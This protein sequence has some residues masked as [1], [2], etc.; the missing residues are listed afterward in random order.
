M[1]VYS[2]VISSQLWEDL[3]DMYCLFGGCFWRILMANLRTEKKKKKSVRKIRQKNG[4]NSATKEILKRTK[5]MLVCHWNNY[6]LH[7]GGDNDGNNVVLIWRAEQQNLP[8]ALY[9]NTV[10]SVILQEIV[11]L[12]MLSPIILT[13][14]WFSTVQNKL[15][16]GRAWASI[17]TTIPS[18]GYVEVCSVSYYVMVIE[19]FFLSSF[20]NGW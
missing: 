11:L 1:N 3:T 18:V 17:A 16:R 8:L 15:F 13:H 4:F 14:K 20:S 10:Y 12:V 2:L 5:Y 7:C 9:R 6:F 19:S